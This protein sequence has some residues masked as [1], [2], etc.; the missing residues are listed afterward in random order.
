MNAVTNT[1]SLFEASLTAS[2]QQMVSSAQQTGLNTVAALGLSDSN[3]QLEQ[4]LD[5]SVTT[6]TLATAAAQGYGTVLQALN[7]TTLGLDEAQNTLA[8]QMIS[9]ESSFK[10]NKYSLDLSTSA[11]VANR[12]A[13][14]KAA[15]AIQQ[16]GQAEEQKTGSIFD[17]NKAMKDQETAFINATGATGK[18]KVAIQQYIDAILK[19]PTQATTTLTI[20]EHYNGG[21][22]GGGRGLGGPTAS[23]YATGGVVSTAAT[24]GNRGGLVQIDEQGI[25]LARLQD[26]TTVIPNS[27]VKSMALN[28]ALGGRSIDKVGVEVSFGGNTDGAFASAF[29]YLVR[30]G[31]IKILKKAI[32]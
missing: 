16:F 7:G 3:V 11:G 26:G 8:Q 9:A 22:S 30:T 14:T 19:I 15:T 13:L 24:G 29:M 4:S 31:K 32:V 25:E 23:K 10:K 1:T 18:A 2:H 27:N 21:N 20:V 12:E 28:G 17:A 6:Y 5:S